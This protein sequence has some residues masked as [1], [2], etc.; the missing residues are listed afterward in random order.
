MAAG[1]KILCDIMARL[2][3]QETQQFQR[4]RSLEE[5]GNKTIKQRKVP[6]KI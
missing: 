4:E 1:K 2:E 6:N 5:R 3:V